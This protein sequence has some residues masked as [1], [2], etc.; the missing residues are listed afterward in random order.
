MTYEQAGDSFSSRLDSSPAVVA[1]AVLRKMRGGS[2]SVLLRASDGTLYVVKMMGNPQGPNVLANEAFGNELA[3]YLGLPVPSWRPISLSDNFLD[4]NR[5]CWFESATGPIRPPAG[6]HFA[7]LA[8]G[9]NS[10]AMADEVVPGQWLSRAGN[11]ADFVAMLVMDLWANHTDN[12][13]A[14]F[15][16]SADTG[17]TT[18]V[19]IDNG[20]L[21]GGPYG[22]EQQRRGAALS[23]DRRVYG[24]P[25]LKKTL[26]RWLLRVRSIDDGV[27]LGLARCIPREWMSEE[28]LSLVLSQLRTRQIAL[29][30][31]L[32]EELPFI[33]RMG[34]GGYPVR[35]KKNALYG[36]DTGQFSNFRRARGELWRN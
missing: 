6:L 10:S 24:G 32:E 30:Q 22:Q 21:F 11:R 9:Q 29:S 23:L 5:L 26:R 34:A 19:F 7:S 12:R 36:Q 17:L 25:S 8:L 1:A 33:A 27:L 15:L 31:L 20:H 13:Q 14:I 4:Q 18:A 28:Y 2:Q 16:Q 35:G 3:R